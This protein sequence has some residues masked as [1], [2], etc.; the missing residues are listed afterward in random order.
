MLPNW[1][2]SYYYY[3]CSWHYLTY[4]ICHCSVTKSCP[5]LCGTMNCN[6]P[7]FHI[8]HYLLVF[9]QTHVHWMSDAIQPSHP[10]SSPSLP[11]FTLSL[12]DA[13]PILPS[14]HLILCHPLSSCL[15]SFPAS[16]SFPMSCLL[17]S[18]GQ[19]I[20]ASASTSVLLMN[21]QGLF[22][23]GL[24][25]LIS[26]QFKGLSRVFYSTTIWKRQFL[27]AFGGS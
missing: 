3:L 5:T 9:A 7:G 14:N 26:L 6:T 22:P 18:G 19:S 27:G 4:C 24:T 25:G 13:L 12:H 11:A 20:G 16:G 2:T 23:L 17:A 1:F 8:L 21:I 15:Q 10:L